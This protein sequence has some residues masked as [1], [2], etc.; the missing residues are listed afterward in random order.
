MFRK[1]DAEWGA[2]PCLIFVIGAA[3]VP[4]ALMSGLLAALFNAIT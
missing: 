3:A 2:G 4:L 1:S